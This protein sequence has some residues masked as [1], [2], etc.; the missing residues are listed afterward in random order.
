MDELNVEKGLDLLSEHMMK[1]EV[2]DI[3]KIQTRALFHLH[4]FFTKHGFVQLMP[5]ILSPMTDPLSGDVGSSVI[6]TGEI[7]YNGNKL[8]LMQSMILHKQL[9]LIS[10]FDKIYIFSPNVRLENPKKK[11]TG[12]HAFEFTQLDFEIT[13]AK[14]KDVFNLMEDVLVSTF[15]YVSKQCPQELSRLGRTLR[16]P[17]KP[18][19]IYTTHELENKYGEDWEIKASLDH[20]EPFWAVCHKREFYDREN[21]ENRGHYLNYDL[22]YP[23]GFGEALSG[24]E[25][26]FEYNQIIKRMRENGLKPES[27]QY[28]VELAKRGM[29]RASAGGGFGIERMI[30]FI[31]GRKHIREV[32]LFPRI[33]G[34]NIIV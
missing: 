3:V 30:R 33:P 28:Y 23:E 25:R 27:Y 18:F 24:G 11:I 19:K 20:N 12:K 31:T 13:N 29:L 34:E 14:M 8:K 17:K 7:E 16:V 22:I 21:P 6:K 4:N 1:S 10:G 26:E 15:D 2:K 32:Q 9:A 5:L